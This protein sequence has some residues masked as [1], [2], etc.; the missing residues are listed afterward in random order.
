MK[1]NN[2]PELRLAGINTKCK[3]VPYQVPVLRV[4]GAVN[5]LTRAKGGTKADGGSGMDMA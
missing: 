3:K 1:T 2:D 5:Q 4:Y